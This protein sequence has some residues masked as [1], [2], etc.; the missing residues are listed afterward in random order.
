MRQGL[1]DTMFGAFLVKHVPAEGEVSTGFIGKLENMSSY[2]DRYTKRKEEKLAKK[3][4]KVA[5]KDAEESEQTES[6]EP[7]EEKPKKAAKKATPKKA[8]AKQATKKSD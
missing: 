8:T 1:Y 3:A 7:V 4:E 2:G 5:V 6:E